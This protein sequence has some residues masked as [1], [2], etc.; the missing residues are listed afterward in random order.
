MI[1]NLFWC[2]PST[3]I[4]DTSRFPLASKI[5]RFTHWHH[6]SYIHQKMRAQ[7]RQCELPVRRNDLWACQYSLSNL[8][9]IRIWFLKWNPKYFSSDERSWWKGV[10]HGHHS[11]K[12]VDI[13]I[14]LW[15]TSSDTIV[16]CNQNCITD[17]LCTFS[18]DIPSYITSTVWSIFLIWKFLI[19]Y[20]AL[21]LFCNQAFREARLDDK[22]Y[23]TFCPC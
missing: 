8:I 21:P 6:D 23:W 11:W 5:P 17:L 16:L 3:V 15:M 19:S 1:Q 14:R 13:A 4:W 22:L 2:P 18:E 20:N 10:R 12:I 9:S 7:S